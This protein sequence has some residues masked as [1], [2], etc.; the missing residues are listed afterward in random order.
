MPTH[1]FGLYP[2]LPTNNWEVNRSRAVFILV[3]LISGSLNK[4]AEIQMEKYRQPYIIRAIPLVWIVLILMG[5]AVNPVTGQRQLA[6][7]PEGMEIHL[8]EEKYAP[9]RQIHGGDYRLDPELSRYVNEV[10]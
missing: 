2:L 3:F 4:I 8:G 9:S 1:P 7:M 10:A 5:C 6:L